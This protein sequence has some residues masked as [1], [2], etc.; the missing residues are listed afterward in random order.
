[1]AELFYRVTVGADEASTRNPLTSASLLVELVCDKHADVLG[2]D[3][4]VA[5]CDVARNVMKVHF[6]TW[7][8]S[9]HFVADR[10]EGL[11]ASHFGDWNTL[12]CG[13]R[14]V[15]APNPSGKDQ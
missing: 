1:M 3:P 13:C 9:G 11:P 8:D 4:E 15:F 14:A 10:L 7:P 2:S 6:A 12:D 5:A